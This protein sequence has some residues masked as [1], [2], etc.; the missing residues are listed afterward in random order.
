M[1]NRDDLFQIVGEIQTTLD[2]M[3]KSGWRGFDCSDRTVERVGR[4]GV[5]VST[6]TEGL[7]TIRSD[8][9][10]CTRCRLAK[11]RTNIVF[12]AGNPNA[13][14][15]FVGEGP[16]FDEDRQGEPFVGAAGQLLTK[17]IQAMGLSRDQVYI[18]NI[19]KCRPPGNRNPMPDEI[20]TCLPFLRR[21]IVAIEPAIICALGTFAAQT[22]LETGETISRL[23]GRFHETGGGVRLMPTYHPAYLLRHPEK[24]REVWA[25]V[26]LLMKALGLEQRA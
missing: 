8:L 16:G 18:S 14:L 13:K 2:V 23:R 15:V 7:E 11:E 25:D 3:A 24:K 5:P 1:V 19:V 26:K 12:G 17:I 6:P 21:Q 10:D 9:G 20:T 22:L 4:W